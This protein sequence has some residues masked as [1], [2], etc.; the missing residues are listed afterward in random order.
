[1]YQIELDHDK[2]DCFDILYIFHKMDGE[3]FEE[4][5]YPLDNQAE[6]QF[7]DQLEKKFLNQLIDQLFDLQK[8]Q[9][10]G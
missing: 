2:D 8:D 7:L 4:L 6:D 3:L 10:N 9:H 1:M 5:H